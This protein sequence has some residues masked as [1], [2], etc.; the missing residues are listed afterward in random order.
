MQHWLYKVLLVIIL[1]LSGSENCFAQSQKVL[2]INSYPSDEFQIEMDEYLTMLLDSANS[3]TIQDVSRP[4]VGWQFK[5]YSSIKIGKHKH[6]WLRLVIKNNSPNDIYFLSYVQ[7]SFVTL[8]SFNNSNGYSVKQSGLLLPLSKRNQKSRFGHLPYIEL[9]SSHGAEQTIYWKVNNE[10]LPHTSPHTNLPNSLSTFEYAI[11][12]SRTKLFVF[13]SFCA[14]LFGLFLYH[15]IMF[16]LLKDAMYLYSAF[17]LFSAALFMMYFKG[18]ILELFLAD[19]PY[20]NY[21]YANGIILCLFLFSTYLFVNKF[22]DAKIW[23]PRWHKVISVSLPI[24][25]VFSFLSGFS[26]YAL[27]VSLVLWIIQMLFLGFIG[28]ALLKKRH[29]LRHYYLVAFSVFTFG[30]VLNI[31][32]NF[33]KFD[34][35]VWDPGDIGIIGLQLF[36]AVGLAKRI[37]LLNEEKQSA[38]TSLILQLQE[39]QQLQQKVTI[40]LEEKIAERTQAIK[41]QNEKLTRLNLLKDKLFSIISHDIKSPLNQLSGTLYMM[42]RDIISKEEIKDVIP[43][44]R[45]NL[46]SNSSFMS[47]LLAW[48]ASQMDGFKIQASRVQA[49]GVTGEI[50]SLL[51]PQAEAKQ[52]SIH[53]LIHPMATV[54]AD[55]EMF[56]SIIRNLLSNAIKFSKEGGRVSITSQTNGSFVTFFVEDTG[57]GIEPGKISKI[58]SSEVTTTR[59]TANEKGTGMGLFICKDFV[60]KNGGS[61]WLE[62]S[63]PEGTLFTFKLPMA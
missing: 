26:Q 4:E 40:E 38:Q 18:Y 8:H 57:I 48:A 47:E 16:I 20:V 56:K 50:C 63:T 22:I 41:E 53:N 11:H 19:H 43:K 42:E 34:Q 3:L 29:P 59:G 17:F 33:I 37:N 39:N 12:Q 58:F 51:Q 1:A 14:I 55:V 31:V 46:S 45:K 25:L 10:F 21:T 52:I 62:K 28:F 6:Y 24:V 15:F 2:T 9:T 7:G 54:W 61:I 49:K 60:E 23:L 30:L 27:L 44:I 36:L 35:G 5:D 32:F 13:V